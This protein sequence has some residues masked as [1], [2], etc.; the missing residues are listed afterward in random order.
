M[1]ATINATVHDTTNQINVSVKN[2]GIPMIGPVAIPV[3]VT[4]KNPAIAP[5]TAPPIHTPISGLFNLEVI[6]YNAGSVIPR[7]AFKA[8]V[9][10]N[11]LKSRFFVFRKTANVA[12]ACAELEATFSPIKY[13]TPYVDK[14]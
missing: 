3:A 14:D 8:A 6:P 12:P 11:D 2:N 1:N 4:W 10:A 7:I 5:P 13:S 9:P